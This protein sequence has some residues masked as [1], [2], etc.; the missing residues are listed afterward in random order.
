MFQSFPKIPRL[1]REIT[2]TEKIDGTH[3]QI[4]W[5]DPEKDDWDI[6]SESR[7]IA[8]MDG[9]WL[10]AGSRNRYITPEDDNFGFARWAKSNAAEL[11]DLGHGRHYGE[12]WGSGIQ[13]GYGLDKG[14][15]R[16]SLFHPTWYPV[17]TCCSAVP[18]LAVAP[19]FDRDVVERTIETLRR[20]GSRA[21]PGYMNPE[22][23]VIWHKAGRQLFKFTLDG[24]GHKS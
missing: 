23:V 18:V 13:R 1:T 24:D 17:P 8:K 11:F 6:T 4:H 9:L 3:G 22:G 15:K 2:I 7:V 16:F 5:L 21:A 19:E 10:L 12:W 14:Q 20:E